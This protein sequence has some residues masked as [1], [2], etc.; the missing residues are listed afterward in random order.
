MAITYYTATS[1]ATTTTTTNTAITVRRFTVKI[2]FHF[3]KTH[4]NKV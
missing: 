4:L 2:G 1:T 3:F